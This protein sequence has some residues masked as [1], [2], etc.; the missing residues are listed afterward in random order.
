MSSTDLFI[1]VVKEPGKWIFFIWEV[2]VE[3]AR[4]AVQISHDCS[5]YIYIYIYRER[6]RDSMY[7]P[8]PLQG[9]DVTQSWFFKQS[10][11]SE[12]FFSWTGCLTKTKEPIL[13]YYLH[14]PRERIIGFKLFSRVLVLCEMES[15][16]SRIWTL[17]TVSISYGDN[18]YTIG[19]SHE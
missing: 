17:V 10:W 1:S 14:I 2:Y 11:H 7:L 18:H 5:E 12:F 9:Q 3:Y 8:T 4:S 16:A 15:A 13:P 19:T 6:E